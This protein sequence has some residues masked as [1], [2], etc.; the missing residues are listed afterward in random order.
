[1]LTLFRSSFIILFLSVGLSTT[2]TAHSLQDSWH[3][4]IAP[5]GWMSSLNGEVQVRNRAEKIHVPFSEIL[6]Q[7]DIAVQ[8]HFEA[9]HGPWSLM[10]DPTYLKISDEHQLMTIG[11][12]VITQTVLIDAGVF[13]RFY[14]KEIA[15]DRQLSLELLGGGRHLSVRNTFEFLTIDNLS[16]RIHMNAPIIGARLK[17][18]LTPRAQLWLRGD[19]GG[20]DVDHI[21]QTW[22]ACAGLSYAAK[23]TVDLGVAY[24]A[25]KI[26]YS[27]GNSSMNVLM[28]GPELGI[29]FHN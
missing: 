24:R 20:F 16:E 21:K 26:D 23:P 28:H 3:Y 15:K 18:D 7:L 13:Y 12:N 4:E 5:Y 27:K 19:A 17:T 11:L 2:A 10:V 1:M 22:S 9:G 29:S 6:K 8:G 25:L 14:A